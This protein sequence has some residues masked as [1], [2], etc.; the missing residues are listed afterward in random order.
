MPDME[1]LTRSLE[2]HLAST[3]EAEAYARGK[4]AGQDRARKQVAW[5]AAALAGFVVAG[6][7]YLR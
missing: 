4:H 6:A 5:L 7:T 2:L 1:R 3:P